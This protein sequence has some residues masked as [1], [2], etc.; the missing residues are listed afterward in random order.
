MKQTIEK[1]LDLADHSMSPKKWSTWPRRAYLVTL[2]VSAPVLVLWNIL[3]MFLVLLAA[4]FCLAGYLVF[5]LRD[6][7]VQMWKGGGE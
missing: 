2:P 5:T 6:C 4:C 1:A 3:V 7:C